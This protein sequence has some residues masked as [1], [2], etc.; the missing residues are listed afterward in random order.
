MAVRRYSRWAIAS[1]VLNLPWMASFG[2]CFWV[3]CRATGPVAGEIFLLPLM[4]WF[5]TGIPAG[6]CGLVAWVKIRSSA[7][8]LRGRW[9]ACLGMLLAAVVPVLAVAENVWSGIEQN[10]IN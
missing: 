1:C 7:G 5:W 3:I 4:A 6:I 9:L 8:N 2:W 10:R